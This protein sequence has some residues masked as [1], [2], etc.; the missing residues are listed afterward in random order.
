MK[1]SE[2]G[3][4]LDSVVFFLLHACVALTHF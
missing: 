3:V 4:D 1:D 2:A